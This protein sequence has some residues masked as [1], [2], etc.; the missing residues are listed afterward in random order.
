M[1]LT[2]GSTFGAYTVGPMLGSGGMGEVYQARDSRLG[3]NVALKV[4]PDAVAHD[5]D[6]LARFAREA[7]ALAALNHPHIAQIYGLEEVAARGALVLE[8]VEG[9][10]L[11]DRLARGPLALDE[12][13][14]IAT[15]IAEALEAAHD[16]GIVHRDLKPAN[17]KITSSGA[18][19]VLDFGLAKMYVDDAPS[20][21]VSLS[22][23]LTVAGTLAGVVVGTAA[24][25]SPEQARGGRVDKRTDVWAFG[26]VLF[27][28]LSG[29]TAFGA[30]TVPDTVVR[31]LSVEPDLKML[32][33]HAPAE[34]VSLLKRCL[35]KDPAR[36]T[37]DI[38]DARLQIEEL[39]RG[40]SH[41]AEHSG[42]RMRV[43]Y[44]GW[45]VAAVAIAAAVAVGV[46]GLRRGPVDQPVVR[47]SLMTPASP[48]PFAFA[49]S[50]DGRSLVYQ[51]QADGQV[52]LWL[53]AFDQEEP[54]PLA[55]TDRVE[56]YL[57]WSPDSRS[58]AFFAD[59]LLKRID[60]DG[61]FVR[62]IAQG[63]NPMRGTWNVDGT[64][65]FGS[66]AGPLSRV[67]AQGGTSAPATTLLPGQSS[68]RWPQ[69]LPDG[70]RFLFLALGMPDVRGIYVGS[71]DSTQITRIMEGEYGFALVP[72]AHLLVAHQG[73]LW[74][75]KLRADYAGIEG[76]MMPVAPHVLAHVSV[77]ALTAL[78]ASDAGPIAYRGTG[79]SK[80]LV[81]LDRAGREADALT[82]PDESQWANLRLSHDGRTVAVSRVIDGNTDVWV[83][84]AARRAP[85]RL[86]FESS[87]D[88]EPMLSPDGSR[89]I[90]ASDPKAGLWDI[91]ERASDGT[92]SAMLLLEES[93]NE[94]PRDLSPDGR[95]LLYA[96]QSA[97]TDYD[98]WALPLTGER[99]P[100]AVVQTPFAEIDAR[101]SPNGRW[102][103]FDSN[104]TGR[105]EIFVQP[106]P[107]PG[108][109]VQVSTSGGRFPRWR[110]DGR[111]LYYIGQ[112]NVLM[113]TAIDST[114]PALSTG[115]SQPLFAI[116][117]NDWYEPSPDGK[118]FLVISTVSAASPITIVLNWKPPEG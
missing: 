62:T 74:A 79:A 27:E 81:W 67:A 94:N 52:R 101:F 90:Y 54:R 108:P 21:D 78:S 12:A 22:P 89:V 51:A 43:A 37:R 115:L 20:R 34:L 8:L 83:I 9:P 41:P 18:V 61:G 84:D 116:S 56:R 2:P 117:P 11:A 19:K 46:V 4:L 65:L 118:R 76:T 29:R 38:T 16:A 32:P 70:R 102:I 97:R 92:G 57:W 35:Q 48:D 53:R 33:S 39:T 72:P 58:I 104:E 42:V 99:K 73:A 93:E 49:V 63:P 88:G 60:L 50:P 55:G 66:S 30:E 107:G 5:H 105:R 98:L 71:L 64:I 59:G 111:E 40:A 7:Q 75:Q 85:R 109:K 114:Q 3:R 96:R 15:Q 26:C 68:H 14:T 80:Q 28:M 44:A 86:T 77:N 13:L 45:F 100:F 24:Y 110:R 6:R 10:T 31:V 113:S 36:R 17:I 25:M 47:L 82:P 23:T 69:F 91:Y 103:A 106:F 95:H 112:D 1:P 87:V